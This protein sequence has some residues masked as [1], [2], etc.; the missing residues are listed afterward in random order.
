MPSAFS[1]LVHVCKYIGKDLFFM[2]IQLSDHFT[3]SKLLR[4]VFPSII[5]MIFTSIYSVV[6][7][8]FVSNFVGKTAFA[9]V[10]LIMP[11]IMILGAIGFMLGT[12]GNAIV[13]KTLGEGEP[14]L[15]QKYFSM[16]IY[17]TMIGGIIV[18]I[19]G[20]IFMPTI[21]KSLGA[22]GEMLVGSILYGRI[23]MISLTCFMLQNVFQS[24]LVT[25][26]KPKLGLL[27]T[28]S[29][30]LT[31]M[32]LD[33]VFVYG[34][35]LGIAGAALATVAS[36]FIGGL[37]P[38]L[39]FLRKN[40]SSLQLCRTR[41]Q[42]GIMIK[43]CTNGSSEFMTNI[44]MSLVNMLY[45]FQLMRIAGENGIATYGVIMYVSFIFCAMFIGYSV[46]C[47]PLIGYNYGAE[48]YP[49]LKNLFHK[50][51]KLVGCAGVCLAILANLLS[52]PL[53]SLFVGYDDALF[54]LTV[55]G[56]RIYSLAF[57][58]NGFS[59]FGSA[60]FTALNNGLISACIAFLRTF[61]FQIV[62]VLVLPYLFGIN[63]VW[64]SIVVAESLAICVTISFF[65]R[66]RHV[67]HYA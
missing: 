67:Y 15:A 8:L 42:P 3:L 32:T 63:G 1:L 28:V 38:L 51:L 13:S 6:D 22:R 48:N 40:N 55:H 7:G 35:K 29:A 21:A 62:A 24:L 64:C 17:C 30:G 23:S 27:I 41:I 16:I 66:K 19:L 34:L 52:A 39:Y 36:E 12:G 45:N 18:S 14:K 2:K 4:F 43:T 58:L 25:A 49:E 37:T 10:N 50:S 53:A 47:A 20:F 11:F 61:A 5:M 26:G 46:G 44:S 54:T 57:L 56:F 65:V 9:S 31:N 60:F 33:A 59:I